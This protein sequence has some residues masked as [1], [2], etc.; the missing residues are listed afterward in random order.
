MVHCNA[1]QY[2]CLRL[3]TTWRLSREQAKLD[4]LR[5]QYKAAETENKRLKDR[6]M[7]GALDFCVRTSC[8]S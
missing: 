2:T 3:L 4:Q 7:V 5:E 8:P 1:L 6:L